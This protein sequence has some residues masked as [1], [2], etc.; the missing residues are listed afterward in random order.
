MDPLLILGGALVVVTLLLLVARYYERR[1]SQELARFAL[2]RGFLFQA[3]G[4]PFTADETQKILSFCR[5][6]AARARNILRGSAGG[7]E[8]VLFDSFRRGGRGGHYET[9]VAFRLLLP[10]F[11]LMAMRHGLN[12]ALMSHVFSRLGLSVLTFDS[13]P[14]FSHNY[15]LLG[16]D[17]DAVRRLFTPALLSYFES[18]DRSKRWAVESGGG[19]LLVHRGW[20][21]LKPEELPPFLDQTASLAGTIK[22]ETAQAAMA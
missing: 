22:K 5:L 6:G 7:L 10:E 9:V 2:E 14:E 8:C 19:W 12:P 15:L 1:R 21:R 20:Q 13:H 16:R 11:E 18:L 3:R 4:E 17:P